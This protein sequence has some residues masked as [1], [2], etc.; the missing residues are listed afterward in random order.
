MTA[1]SRLLRSR[2]EIRA[3]GRTA[4]KSAPALTEAQV[5]ALASLLAPSLTGTKPERGA[6]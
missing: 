3:A 4:A 6:A 2:E 5:N 1:P